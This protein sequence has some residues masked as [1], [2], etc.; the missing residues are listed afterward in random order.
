M[1][2][3]PVGWPP[4]DIAAAN[5]QVSVSIRGRSAID[6]PACHVMWQISLPLECSL[7]SRQCKYPIDTQSMAASKELCT[8]YREDSSTGSA[9]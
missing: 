5:M 9:M 8:I 6:I 1:A 4:A 7:W 2:N 3:I